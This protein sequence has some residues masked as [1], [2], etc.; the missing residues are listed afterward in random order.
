MGLPEQADARFQS[1]VL[2]ENAEQLSGLALRVSIN[3]IEQAR[4]T[5]ERF[6]KSLF[7]LAP[8]GAADGIE[9]P[10]QCDADRKKRQHERAC[11][12]RRSVHYYSPFLSSSGMESS[13][14][15]EPDC[16]TTIFRPRK[17]ADLCQQ[18]IL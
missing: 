7:G 4:G 1:G 6:F 14:S 17:P 16:G 12:Q 13:M 18:T 15:I 2:T 5:V 3:L 10:R 11:R 9:A 8:D